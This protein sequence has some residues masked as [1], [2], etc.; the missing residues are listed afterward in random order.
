MLRTQSHSGRSITPRGTIER[1][2]PN[3]WP[4][5]GSTVRASRYTAPSPPAK[6]RD[7]SRLLRMMTGRKPSSARAWCATDCHR[8]EV[9][10]SDV[11]TSCLQFRPASCRSNTHLL[12]RRFAQG[13]EKK[14]VPYIDTFPAPSDESFVMI[15]G[16]RDRT[17][18]FAIV[19]SV[20]VDRTHP[21]VLVESYSGDWI[22]RRAVG[23]MKD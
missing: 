14:R 20:H 22:K 23:P 3:E 11:P 9:E 2:R 7:P 8:E 18:R 19:A 4:S 21:V 12:A 13:V 16:E 10:A 1:V 15:R 5:T 6:C 17:R